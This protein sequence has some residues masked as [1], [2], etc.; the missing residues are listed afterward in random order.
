M[1]VQLCEFTKTSTELYTLNDAS[2]SICASHTLPGFLRLLPVF[3]PPSCRL[4]TSSQPF[5]S[6]RPL[7]APGGDLLSLLR[8]H[9]TSKEQAFSINHLPLPH[10]YTEPSSGRTEYWQGWESPR[11][12]ILQL[13]FFFQVGYLSSDILMQSKPRGHLARNFSCR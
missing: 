4:H 11:T 10:T 3:G 13:D 9:P 6:P 8:S 12:A 7:S 2:P 5:I 1:T